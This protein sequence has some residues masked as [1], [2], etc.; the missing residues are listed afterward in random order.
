MTLKL[1]AKCIE[2]KTNIV[3]LIFSTNLFFYLETL[4]KECL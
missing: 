1:K 2:L 4:K 3:C